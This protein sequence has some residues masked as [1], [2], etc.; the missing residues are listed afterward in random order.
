[1]ELGQANSLRVS[2]PTLSNIYEKFYPN[3]I[4][5]SG[6]LGMTYQIKVP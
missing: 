6:G 1:M 5:I 4:Q 3:Q 2:R